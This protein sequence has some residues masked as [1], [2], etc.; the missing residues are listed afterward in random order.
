MLISLTSPS[1]EFGQEESEALAKQ[2]ISCASISL[3]FPVF[4]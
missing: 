4:A 1:L 3:W 2:E